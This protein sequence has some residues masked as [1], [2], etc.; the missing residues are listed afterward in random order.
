VLADN[1]ISEQRTEIARMRAWYRQWFGEELAPGPP[2]A[3]A[4]SGLDELR[5]AGGDVDRVFLKMMIP[6]HAGAIMMADGVARSG[7]RAQIQRL[8]R[9]IVAAQAKE[10]GTM[11]RGRERWYPPLG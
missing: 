8:A 3:H 9:E 1:I 2:D 4:A 10:V 7:A 6:H 11:Q 5:K